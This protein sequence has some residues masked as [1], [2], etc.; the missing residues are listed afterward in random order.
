MCNIAAKYTHALPVEG[1][2]LPG[3]E[4]VRD[5]DP[6]PS[7]TIERTIRAGGGGARSCAV[8]MGTELLTKPFIDSVE[9]R[10]ECN[11]TK[12]LATEINRQ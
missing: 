1:A 3:E 9:S 7:Q 11:D 5:K 6:T 10:L 12:V 8:N 2:G 4:P